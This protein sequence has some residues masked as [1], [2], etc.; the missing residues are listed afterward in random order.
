MI[1][2]KLIKLNKNNFWIV[3]FASAVFTPL[4]IS[5]IFS[6]AI[7]P[8]ETYSKGEL[9]KN[10]QC[11]NKFFE[12]NFSAANWFSSW[13]GVV[14]NLSTIF[15]IVV[16]VLTYK[17]NSESQSMVNHFSNL[18][19]FNNY[20]TNE[21]NK[22]DYLHISSFDIVM[23]YGCIYKQS[24][25]GSLECS[26]EYASLIAQYEKLIHESN[27]LR[28]CG[29]NLGYSYKTHQ[30]TV[31]SIVVNFGIDLHDA[32]RT[33]F[34]EIEDQLILLIDK[35]NISFVC[36]EKIKRLPETSYR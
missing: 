4:A 16:A 3:I 8:Y 22:L 11:I 30:D 34:K 6:L 27:A 12:N 10:V 9:C 14:Y 1:N 20:V 21:I 35:V 15:G 5:I 32:T 17:K 29:P 18:G 23:W 25:N 36:S 2:I 31:R 26:N 33:G 19:L 13:L 28:T 24:K 7:F